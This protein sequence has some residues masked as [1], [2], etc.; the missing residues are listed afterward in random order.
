VVRYS[1]STHGRDQGFEAI[2]AGKLEEEEKMR[3]CAGENCSF[4]RE[5]WGFRMPLPEPRSKR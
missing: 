4:G 5:E 1:W 2:E 3:V